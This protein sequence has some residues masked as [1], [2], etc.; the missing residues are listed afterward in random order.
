MYASYCAPWYTFLIFGSDAIGETLFRL[1]DYLLPNS[2]PDVVTVVILPQRHFQAGPKIRDGRVCLLAV[3]TSQTVTA[4]FTLRHKV[5][6]RLFVAGENR[7]SI[8][9]GNTFVD[10]FAPRNAHLYQQPG[11]RQRCPAVAETVKTIK[12]SDKARRR[13]QPDCRRRNNDY[14]EYGAGKIPASANLAGF[15]RRSLLRHQDIWFAVFLVDGIVELRVG[16]LGRQGSG[17]CRGWT[18]PC[19]NRLRF[20]K[21]CLHSGWQPSRR[22]S[23]RQRKVIPLQ[24]NDATSSLSSWT[25]TLSPPSAMRSVIAKTKPKRRQTRQPSAHEVEVY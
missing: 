5:G 20:A 9:K 1:K 23:G 15:Q 12:T 16:C 4:T 14:P 10:T 13:R 22:Q 21:S 11:R 6:S 3:N 18:S 8:L 17:K 24:N 2:E 7:E 25:A 19:L